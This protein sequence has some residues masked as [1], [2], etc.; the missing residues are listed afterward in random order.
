MSR[1]I[2]EVL[3]AYGG[4]ARWNDVNTIRAHKRFGGAIWDLKQVTG[5]VEDGEVTVWVQEQRTSLHPFTAADRA[6]AY[7]P[8]RVAITTT[9]G[10]TVDELDHPR[11]SFAGHDLHTPWNSLQLAYFTGYAMWTY[12]TEPLHLTL[13]GITLTEG[14][15]WVD[16]GQTWRRL[17]VDYPPH[18]ATHSPSQ[19]L[20]VDQQG[21]IRRRDYQVDIAG[22]SPAAHYVS[23]FRCVDGI[24]VPANR[25]IYVRDVSGHAVLDQLVVSI[26]L[27]DI[28]IG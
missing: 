8:Q 6:S 13:P 1:L 9:G 24:V 27:T 25:M 3:D 5:V 21:L 19:V 15:P 16:E 26:E 22:G 2:D 7:T 12:L 28:E 20:Y 4:T 14:A 10:A 17:H 23:D 18:I 11:D